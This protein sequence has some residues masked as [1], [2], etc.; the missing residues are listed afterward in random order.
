VSLGAFTTFAVK[1]RPSNQYMNSGRHHGVINYS[2]STCQVIQVHT[3]FICYCWTYHLGQLTWKSALPW[4]FNGLSI[5]RNSRWRPRWP[6]FHERGHNC[7]HNS[8]PW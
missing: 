5:L 2:C 4:T 1:H 7:L 8:T 6:P 3:S